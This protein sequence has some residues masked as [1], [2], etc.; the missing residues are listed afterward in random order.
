M[1]STNH[2]LRRQENTL[3]GVLQLLQTAVSQDAPF[4]LENGR[5]ISQGF[6][7]ELDEYRKLSKGGKQELSEIL[8]K[9]IQ[10]T[11]ISSLKIK[12]T[13]V[14]GYF[15]E[16]PSS[17]SQRLPERFIRR[18][19]L[20]NAERFIT[21]ELKKFE[22]NIFSAEQKE[23]QREAQLFQELLEEVQQKIPLFQKT[24]ECIAETDVVW[25]FAK[26]S[27][28]HR[29]SRP[30][31]SK[32]N[33]LSIEKGRHPVVEHFLQKNKK[34]V[35][36]P[37]S[38]QMDEKSIFHLIT[39][40]N[41]AGKSTFLRQNAIILYLFHLGSFVPAESAS[42][43]L[44]DK[45]FTRIGSGDSLVTGE[46]TFLVE[47]QE[48]AHILQNAT[49]ESFVILDEI[50]RG[51]STFDGL[52]IA[53]AISEYLHK[54]GIKTLFAT[55]Y[56][57]LISLCEN[58]PLA[59]NFS[60]AVFENDS[61]VNFLHQIQKGGA[62]KSFGIEVA[63]ISGIPL[64]VIKRAENILSELEVADAKGGQVS[65][66]ATP[67]TTKEKE[68]ENEDVQSS[69]TEEE[70]RSLDLHNMTPLEALN[71]LVK[72]QKSLSKKQ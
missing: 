55:H 67:N 26:V 44:V 57:E 63:K 40:P 70:L 50:G 6:D 66:F 62:E 36:V 9:E 68:F 2:T 32:T 5:F 21:E 51:T 29:F 13:Q 4:F 59:K 64:S 47:M 43:P 56:H 14:F 46:S 28:K 16:V 30:K 18:Q 27:K 61:G 3:F 52:S 38:L 69:Q 22:E 37:N 31:I 39:G 72:L 17:Q 25:G 42:I 54:K 45:I 58:L 10:A 71:T 60:V 49:K 53:W 11:G 12:F 41:M 24:A 34:E 15:F 19:T 33:L 1:D 7:A 48:A 65:L 8:E 35:F 20:T 23:K